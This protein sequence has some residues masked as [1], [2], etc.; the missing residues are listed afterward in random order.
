M[1]LAQEDL[2][3]ARILV[4]D[5]SVTIQKVV[6]LTFSKENFT[7][8]QARSGEEAIRKAKE[9]RPDLVLLDLVMPDMNG[10][11]VCAVLRAEPALRNMPIILLAGTFESF[12]QQRG[13]Q[14]GANDFVTKPFE[15]QVLI[16]K[17]KQC[18]F[19]KAM[20]AGAVANFGRPAA[21]AVTVR[22]PPASATT[23]AGPS[24]A[25]AP[26]VAEEPPLPA[27]PQEGAWQLLGDGS[28]PVLAGAAWPEKS[29]ASD[30][31]QP[32]SPA[33]PLAPEDLP[34]D[35]SALDLELLPAGTEIAAEDADVLP[36][37]ESLS[38][39]D[40]LTA[41]P[42]LLA[43]ASVRGATAGEVAAPEPVFELSATETPPLP[44]VEVG[45]GE[46]PALSVE[47]LLGSG[48]GEV[49]P[50]DTLT[51]EFPELDLTARAEATGTVAAE[52]E[53]PQPTSSE[54]AGVGAEFPFAEAGDASR[55]A[56]AE[57]TAF[58]VGVTELSPPVLVA[59]DAS[60][61]ADARCEEPPIDAAHA[62]V[63]E[64]GA[65]S[66]VVASVAA[67]PPQKP[68]PHASV[69]IPPSEMAAMREAV[70]ERVAD[71]LRRELSEK[72]LD[73]FEKIVWE[74]VPDLAEILITKEIERIRR[75]AEEDKLS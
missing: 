28:E 47:E 30:V 69:G 18:L 6:E 64:L 56:G 41:T 23:T 20:E 40:L 55:E 61:L 73:R 14:A 45:K 16:G 15:S 57:D 31:E 5:D 10:Y 39:D 72:L 2:M 67:P 62:Q 7:L 19:A 12:D 52:V 26:P 35:L 75:L 32:I 58:S 59:A 43:D 50:A 65:A 3:S 74:V 27:P 68:A 42:E 36:L 54:V 11:D 22:I 8:T 49:A 13:M 34:L 46:P 48:G 37:P 60:S 71:E 25:T 4:V 17:V 21:E 29:D 63:E 33:P 53:P 24:L 44:M 66:P 38:L 51:L 9:V 1:V 70:T